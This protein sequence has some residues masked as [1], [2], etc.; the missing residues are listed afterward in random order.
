MTE[1]LECSLARP[2]LA[3][4]W[5]HTATGGAWY[6]TTALL[7]GRD[8]SQCLCVLRLRGSEPETRLT[9]SVATPLP[10]MSLLVARVVCRARRLSTAND[11]GGRNTLI[12]KTSTEPSRVP[13]RC[14][15]AEVCRWITILARG[16]SRW[17]LNEVVVRGP[18]HTPPPPPQIALK[19]CAKVSAPRSIN[20]RSMPVRPKRKMMSVVRAYER[21]VLDGG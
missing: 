15:W 3:Q 5:I 4:S 6:W 21:D 8:R 10:S 11:A 9:G 13:I 12:C 18:R 1:C 2:V 16:S 17:R 7:S 19:W 14:S 20:F